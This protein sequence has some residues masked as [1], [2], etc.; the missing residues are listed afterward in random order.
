MGGGAIADPSANVEPN[1]RLSHSFGS[2]VPRPLSLDLNNRTFPIARL[3]RCLLSVLAFATG[4][5]VRLKPWHVEVLCLPD[6]RPIPLEYRYQKTLY[7]IVDTPPKFTLGVCIYHNNPVS[8]TPSY[9]RNCLWKTESL[10]SRSLVW[11]CLFPCF[12]L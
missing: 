9:A 7:S 11:L 6:T 4:E 10:R 1:V 12:H 2:W 8:L 3:G 5:P